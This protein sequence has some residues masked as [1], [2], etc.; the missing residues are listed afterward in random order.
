MT[1]NTIYSFNQ[2]K[3]KQKN[4]NT[5]N[6]IQYNHMRKFDIELKKMNSKMRK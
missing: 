1:L 4:C 6:I 5:Y 3:T 2:N